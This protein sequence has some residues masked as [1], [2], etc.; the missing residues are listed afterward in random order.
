MTNT[1]ALY[2]IHVAAEAAMI[3]ADYELITACQVADRAYAAYVAA[4]SAARA[5]WNALPVGERKDSA[6]QNAYDT[7]GCDED[8][9]RWFEIAISTYEMND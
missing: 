7:E 3:A 9:L 8:E 4:V 1:T 2:Q 5:E 6:E